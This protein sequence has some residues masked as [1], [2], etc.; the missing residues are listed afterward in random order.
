MWSKPFGPFLEQG[1]FGAELIRMIFGS[2]FGSIFGLK[3]VRRLWDAHFD[4]WIFGWANSDG[5]LKIHRCRRRSACCSWPAARW[6][7][8]SGHFRN[9]IWP[10]IWYVYVPPS[11]GSWRSPIDDMFMIFSWQDFQPQKVGDF[12]L[13]TG[14]K[15]KTSMELFK[16]WISPSGHDGTNQG[17]AEEPHFSFQW[18]INSNIDYVSI[19]F[20]I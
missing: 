9:K 6:C 7:D 13:P 16:S 17:S 10:E 19:V 12:P 15:V 5:P 20:L 1:W 2:I 4:G 3:N 8:L 14:S 11:V 18:V